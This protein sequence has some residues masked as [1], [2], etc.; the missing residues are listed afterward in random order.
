MM[1]ITHALIGIALC[2][3]F[4]LAGNWFELALA[5]LFAVLPDI[6][7][8]NSFFGTVLRPVSLWIY[9]KLGHRDYTHSALFMTVCTGPM[10]FTNYFLLAFTAMGS[11]LLSDALTFTGIPLLIPFNKN[12]T[13]FGGP[14]RTGSWMETI[15]CIICLGVI[16][17]VKI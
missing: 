14:V 9:S 7:H 10:L 3:T 11:H 8:P 15:I 1:G 5:G 16:F 17:F 4:G 6:D 13:I 2:K 12:F